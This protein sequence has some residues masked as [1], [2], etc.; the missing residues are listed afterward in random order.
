MNDPKYVGCDVHLATIVVEVHNASGNAICQAII[1]T[2]VG[3]L[4]DFFAAH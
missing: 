4:Q 2:K 1:E 3:P